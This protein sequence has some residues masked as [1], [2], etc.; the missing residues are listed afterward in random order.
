MLEWIQSNV[1]TVTLITLAIV[2]LLTIVIFRRR[3]NF[4]YGRT[5]AKPVDPAEVRRQNPP[6]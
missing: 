4:G 2:V 6:N 1:V 5:K 3:R